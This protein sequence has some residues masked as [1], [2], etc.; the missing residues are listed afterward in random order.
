MSK[1][2]L[3]DA[4]LLASQLLESAYKDKA[5]QLLNTQPLLCFNGRTHDTIVTGYSATKSYSLNIEAILQQHLSA[6]LL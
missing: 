1:H 3:P 5:G 6:M 2:F 4:T